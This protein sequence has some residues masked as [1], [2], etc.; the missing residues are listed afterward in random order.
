MP[1]VVLYYPQNF[2]VTR[3]VPY[4]LLYLAKALLKNE[5]SVKII[6]ANIE[7]EPLK[8]LKDECKNAS[9]VG[10]S[11]GMD[12]QVAMALPASKIA[13]GASCT[14]VWGGVYSTFNAH[15][16]VNLPFVDCIV[17]GEGEK[18]MVSI[19][20]VGITEA[21]NIIYKRDGEILSNTISNFID[22]NEYSP[23]PFDLIDIRKYVTTYKNLKVIH[24]T[25]SR[26][27][28]YNCEFC[29]QP[30]MW[31]RK[32]R[33]LSPE[34]ALLEIDA[35]IEMTKATGVYF[36]DDNFLVDRDRARR[37]IEGL[38]EREIFWGC[39]T[40]A[41][42]LTEEIIHFMKHNG[43]YKLCIGAESG[44]Q[45]TLDN[46]GKGLR[47][48]EI[49]RVAELFGKY[50]ISAEFYFMIGYIG[51]N[52]EDINKTLDLIDRVEKVCDAET[53]LRVAT[54]FYGTKYFDKAQKFGFKK[55]DFKDECAQFWAINPP[56]LP[57]L[58][59][60]E[61][62]FIQNIATISLMMYI[63]ENYIKDM[64]MAKRIAYIPLSQLLRYRWEHRFWS[65]P[66]D[67]EV[68][69]WIR[70]RGFIKNMEKQ[71]SP[72]EK[73]LCINLSDL[74]Q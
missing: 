55:G 61:N 59:K 29:Y 33:A 31:Q 1:K 70:K 16:L 48:E 37:I 46:M 17:K 30:S 60:S 10:I 66:I 21:P 27:C 18:S 72:I 53:F 11:A 65:I 41:D 32:W 23:L 36:L 49:K 47:V 19:L 52:E 67:Y 14:V 22:L 7:K 62:N 56:Y 3:I 57:W 68:Y 9:L 42:N 4:S 54:P 13:K 38:N 51:E 12:F 71:I 6:D 25:S 28:P 45:K 63:R 69:R 5:Y 40:R 35:L 26:G 73:E 50:D 58:T 20:E 2:A 74:I 39:E 8:K 64:S 24:F 43:C 44:S 34:N 15:T